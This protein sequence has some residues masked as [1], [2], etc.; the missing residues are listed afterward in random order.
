MRSKIFI[1][2]TAVFVL[3]ILFPVYE[4]AGTKK[5]LM[6]E[7]LYKFNRVQ[8]PQVSP[9][10]KWIAYVVSVPSLKENNSTSGLRLLSINGGEPQRLA[11]DYESCHSPRWSP[12][13]KQL[14]FISSKDDTANLYLMDIKS[15]KIRQLSKSENGL[16]SPLWSKDGKFIL[17]RS[18]VLPEGKT[19]IENWT[20]DELPQCEART[21]NRLLFR[22]WD[23]WLG[24]KRN[25]LFKVTVSD[26]SLKDL[27][28]A[29]KDVPPVSLGSGADFSIS[30]DGKE[31]CYVRNDDKMLAT[32]TNQDIFLLNLETGKETKLTTNPALDHMPAYSPDGRFISYTSMAKPGYESDRA[33]L[34]IFDRKSGKHISLTEKLDRS[35]AQVLWTPDS[36]AIYFTCREEGFSSIYHVDLK[37]NVKRITKEGYNVSLAITPKGTPKGDRLIFLRSFNHMPYEMFSMILKK[38]NN[39]Y[40]VTQLTEEN[41]DF[42][43]SYDLPKLEEFWF[44][45]ADGDRVH[46]FILRPP[47]FDPGKKYPAVL[48]IHGGPQ[49]MWADRFMTSWWTFQLISSPG[50]VGVFIDPR[51]STGY[52]SKFRAQVSKNYGGHTYID[53][54]KGVDYVIENYTF[55]DK[56]R[57]AA[58]GGSYGGYSVNWIMGH[59][60]R[61]KC[62]V[63][64]AS[65]YNLVS[66]YGSTEELWYPAWD[67]GETPWDEPEVYAKWSPHLHAK[68]FKTPTLVTHG[69]LDFRVHFAESLQL[70]TALQ[71]QGVPSRLVAFPDEGHVISSPQNNVRWWKEIHRWLAEYL[72]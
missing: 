20:K 44:K 5:P 12:D 47:G 49:N 33:V 55:V 4:W 61:F 16:S 52:G 11:K 37:G 43:A 39:K 45:G 2:L 72:K 71:R 60:N 64:H 62:I 23:R 31:I 50:Y 59:N 46:G 28:P 27:T 34:K 1:S 25:H 3:I 68:K 48:T 13:G 56:E 17:C 6:P 24:D 65:L 18:R 58:V 42:L 10:G 26:G 67:M 51:G 14:L 35:I 32:S 66:F 29:D 41:R 40:K 63:S 22:Q 36:K 57:L 70:F 9:D 38:N 69:Q 54:M 21:I 15:K 8:D 53:L 7:D 19:D 30:P